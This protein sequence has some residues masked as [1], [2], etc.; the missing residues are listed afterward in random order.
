M[1][2][3][4]PVSVSL[5]A[6]ARRLAAGALPS[7]LLQ[8]AAIASAALLA[9]CGG[10]G[11]DTTPAASAASQ[12]A[13]SNQAPVSPQTVP[14]TANAGLSAADLAQANA[15]AAQSG[16][17]GTAGAAVLGWKGSTGVVSYRV[18]YGTASRA[19]LQPLG[20]GVPATSP[21][22][23]I[24]G[25]ASGQTYYFSVTGVDAGGKETAYSDEMTKVIS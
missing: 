17:V 11:T 19:Y 4:A 14:A 1:T 25:L 18:Y 3:S 5:S 2:T 16:A 10:G 21:A 24:N 12:T 6:S 8:I 15:L 13:V 23:T 22:M 20:S 9:A 7:R